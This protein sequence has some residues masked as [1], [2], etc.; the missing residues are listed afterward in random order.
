MSP[1]LSLYGSFLAEE[2]WISKM[3]FIYQ[4][5]VNCDCAEEMHGRFLSFLY[6]LPFSMI[7]RSS[8][9]KILIR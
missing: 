5:K 3:D 1:D 2:K 9:G 7:T 4:L 8:C 6:R